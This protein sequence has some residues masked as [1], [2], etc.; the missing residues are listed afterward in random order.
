MY[1]RKPS[2]EYNGPKLEYDK[3]MVDGVLV[4]GLDLDSDR[5]YAE[6]DT[7]ARHR[8]LG[9]GAY[10][11]QRSEIAPEYESLAIAAD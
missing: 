4:T 6:A 1:Q 10:A 7:I 5:H 2:F 11:L 8:R 3:Q 9:I